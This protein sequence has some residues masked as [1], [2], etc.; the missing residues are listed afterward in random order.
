MEGFIW[1]CNCAI[2]LQGQI[3]PFKMPS[4]TQYMITSPVKS[5]Q[6]TRKSGVLAFH[7]SNTLS[8]SPVMSLDNIQIDN[9]ASSISCYVWFQDSP[10]SCEFSLRTLPQFSSSLRDWR[11]TLGSPFTKKQY[12]E[13]RTVILLIKIF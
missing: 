13:S 2:T 6:A 11:Y 4:G 1:I 5:L 10:E 8:T 7:C 9:P 12:M 3:T